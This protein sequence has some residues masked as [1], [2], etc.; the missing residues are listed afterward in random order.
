MKN[1]PLLFWSEADLSYF[2]DAHWASAIFTILAILFHFLLG[3]M[4]G[5]VPSHD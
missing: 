3:A 4:H 5:A 2:I 1:R